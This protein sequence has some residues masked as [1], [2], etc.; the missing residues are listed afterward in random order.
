[1]KVKIT[2][3]STG[4]WWY[5]NKIGNEYVV[6]PTTFLSGLWKDCYQLVS[7]SSYYIHK[8]DCEIIENKGFV[9]APTPDISVKDAVFALQCLVSECYD[10]ET[11][12][13]VE[14]DCTYVNAFGKTFVCYKEEE[15]EEITK[16]VAVL[17]G[18]IS[19]P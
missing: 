13:V 16:A 17:A 2:K 6:E 14:R 8:D 18:A 5:A 15:L 3:C 10:T 11:Q 7:N 12:I 19:E 4:T 9:A 1:M